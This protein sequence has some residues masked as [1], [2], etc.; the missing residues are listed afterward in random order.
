MKNKILSFLVLSVLALGML[1][2]VSAARNVDSALLNGASSVTV[3]PGATIPASLTVTTSG[4]GGAH[5]WHSTAYRIGTGSWTCVNTDD[6]NSAGTF[7]ESFSVAAPLSSGSYNFEVIAYQDGSCSTGASSTYTLTNGIVVTSSSSTCTLT[8]NNLA[9]YYKDPL[10]LAWTIGSDCTSSLYD[11]FYREG[12]CA[13]TPVLDWHPIATNVN[14]DEYGWTSGFSEGEYCIKVEE[15]GAGTG[16]DAMDAT[17]YIDNIAPTAEANGPYTCDEDTSVTL[18]SSGSNDNYGI[19][20]YEWR[21]DD[22]VVGTGS[23]YDYS[24]LDGPASH[25]VA[26]TVVDY[27]GNS[28]TDTST[29]TEKNVDPWSVDA[30]TDQTVNEGALVSFSG[31]ATD[32]SGDSLTYTWNFG[33]ESET[34]TGS[35]VSHTYAQ[36]GIYNVTLTVTDGD[37]G[38]STDTLTVT[39][40]DLDPTAGFSD[41]APKEEGQTVSF[42]DS[43]TSYDGIVSWFWDFG[44]GANSTLE[45]PTHAYAVDGPYTV[46]LTVYE[47]DGDSNTATDSVSITDSTPVVA[48]SWLPESPEEGQSVQFTDGSSAYDSPMTYS[49]SFGDSATSTEQNPTHTYGDNGVY[50]VTLT[51]TDSDGSIA[52]SSDSISVSN[53][54]PV[55]NA[56]ADQSGIIGESV[57]FTGSMT[58]QGTLDTHTFSWNFGDG[59]TDT[60]ASVCHSYSTKGVYTA[61]LTVTDDDGGVGTDTATATI[62]DYQIDLSEG[63]N[64]IS[65]PLVPADTNLQNVLDP[66]KENLEKVWVYRYD[67]TT[68]KNVWLYQLYD[69]EE[70]VGN[71][72]FE[73]IAPGLGYYLEMSDS[74]SLLM[75]GEK[76]YDLGGGLTSPPTQEVVPGW[77]LIGHYG[78]NS[79][80]SKANAFVTLSGN[81]ATMLDKDGNTELNLFSKEGYWLFVTGTN[82]LQYA[83][84]GYAYA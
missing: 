53:V 1:G 64:L 18:S 61:T 45:N 72:E 50:T 82:T 38:I 59:N 77:N 76:M 30:G 39:V 2:M 24:C 5:D 22:V 79:G 19:S 14:N 70:W 31:S 67:E 42:T 20:S 34:E 71:T 28:N 58:D 74:D 84:S 63:W 75:N 13:L 9:G 80:M 36:E 8:M 78:M 35:T 69:G 40:N 15:A 65:F 48:F 68:G 6:H 66:I 25:S 26:L 21:V 46:S 16:V 62:Y 60:G 54:N 52:S 7:T 10:S 49:W 27:A 51:V 43:S 44:D 32:V 3:L 33:D 23:T 4:G 47:A 17:F 11:V 81:Y 41:N 57:C 83:P 55:A 73:D 12:S 37:G 56:G 29:I